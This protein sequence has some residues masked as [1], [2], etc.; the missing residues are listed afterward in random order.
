[1]RRR[2]FAGVVG[3]M[4]IVISLGL[5]GAAQE[6][7]MCFGKRA[8]LVGTPGDDVLIGR[9]GPDVIVGLDGND[10]IIGFGG[11][12]RICGGP[13]TDNIEG[14]E[15]SDLLAGDD[16]TD[17]LSGDEG[18]DQLFGGLDGD[19]L[20]GG[21]GD[22]LVAGEA[23]AD[24]AGYAFAPAAVTVSIAAQTASG[25]DGNDTLM[26]IEN[27]Q[28]SSF[29]DHLIGDAGPNSLDAGFGGIDL[30]EGGDGDDIL[31]I[32]HPDAAGRMFGQG[33]NDILSGSAIRSDEM[34]GGDGADYFVGDGG[35]DLL[36]GG[37]GPDTLFAG[38]GDDVLDGLDGVSGNDQL[39]GE[40][41]VDVCSA[42]P[43]DVLVNCP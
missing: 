26:S 39:D 42:D 40:G 20:T 3:A 41:G 8:T 43:G 9:P 2:H 32:T 12:D 14:R 27:A 28:G 1:M 36:T 24:L 6:T 25:G 13:G 33:G 4:L 10:Q 15:K 37:G 23:G 19:G 16:G 7:P 18:E 38:E 34:D 30:M 31:G 5:P 22:D 11:R 29:D 21:L 17:F 35:N